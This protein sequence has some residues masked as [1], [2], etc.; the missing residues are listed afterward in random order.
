MTSFLVIK[1]SVCGE[2]VTLNL[3]HKYVSI[4]IQP[5]YLNFKVS[6]RTNSVK[7]D[8]AKTIILVVIILK[9]KHLVSTALNAACMVKKNAQCW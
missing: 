1:S 8:N 2:N 7:K 9:K 3:R 4:M 5:L 6:H